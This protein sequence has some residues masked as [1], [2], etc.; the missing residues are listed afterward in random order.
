MLKMILGII[1]GFVVW[2]VLWIGSHALFGVLSPNWYGKIDTELMDAV[3]K[4]T[5][6][7]VDSMILITSLIRSVIFS[8][9][10]GYITAMIARENT[11][12]TFILGVLLL[13]FGIMV[14]IGIWKYEPV[15]YH[16]SF[17]ILLIPMTVLGGKL[18]KS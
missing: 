4:G 5:D 11:I 2:S 8:I 17:L 1:V 12:S 7:T 14:Q 9:I 13:L 3:T 10:A 6:Y 15:W 16:L 18:K